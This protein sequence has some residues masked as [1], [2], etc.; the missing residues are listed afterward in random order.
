MEQQDI[1]NKIWSNLDRL[2]TD[3]NF[4][5]FRDTKLLELIGTTLGAEKLDSIFQDKE[6]LT[7]LT[8]SYSITAPK[9]VF[10]FIEELI[11]ADN[12]KSV[13]DPWLT[14]SSPLLYIQ[15]D[16]LNGTCINQSE[17]EAIKTLFKDKSKNFKLGDTLNQLSQSNDKFDLIL[18]FPPF[19]M[20]TQSING[21]K[22][23]FDFATTLLLKCGEKIEN[24]GKMIFL[25][26]NSFLMDDKVKEAL[27]KEG[28]FVEAVFAIPSGA[29]A[30]M[31][32]ISSNLILVSKNSKEK[33]FVAE[34]SQDETTNKT[35][36]QNFKS[37]KEGKAVQL[38]TLIDLSEF[39]SLNALVSEKEMQELVKRIGYPPILLT[40]ISVSI[41]ALKGDNSED[42]E[43]LANSIYLPKVGNSPVVASLSELKIKPKNYYQIQLDETKANSIYVA[44]YFNTPVGKKLRESLEAGVVI[45]QI[46][47]SQLSKCIFFL[48]DLTTQADLIEV[49]NKIQQFSF[50]LAELKRNLWKQPKSYKSI[51]KELKTINQEEKLENW[52]DK[53]PFPISSIL[54]RYYATKDNS[55]KIEHLFHFFEA[56]SEFLSM[57]ML[58]ALVQ[59]KEFYKEESHKWIGKDEKFQNWY[60]RATFGNWNNLTSNLSKAIRTYLTE[61]D[62]KEYCKNLFGNPSE[63]FLSMITSKGIVNV[64]FEVANLRNKWKGHGGITNEEE[65]NQRVLTLEQQLNEFR[66]Y[67][68]DAFEDTRMLSP[69][70]SSFED[71]IFT[72]N[73]KE[74]IGARTPFNEITIKSL[75]PLDRKKLYLSNSQQ[76][77]PLELLPFIKFIEASDAIYFYTSIESKD[78]RWVSYHFDKEAELKQPAD[79]ELF[80][81]FD[82]LK[83]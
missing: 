20:W 23:P 48:P 10:K 42:V 70:T 9:Y 33:T 36:I 29:F 11:K 27:K 2:R 72:F 5:G 18:S 31:T 13:L 63:A 19:G 71:G 50:R 82:F 75:I 24:T 57:L 30:P 8:N 62:K 60:L 46:S 68:A 74:L 65:N 58:S 73:A 15:A 45:P 47:K 34:V 77:K 32:N 37:Q 17:F 76:T 59:D 78:V 43:H 25:V 6:L 55:K 41:N 67:I 69:T 39:K 51:A 1:K 28:L 3:R 52:I 79:N 56:F 54:W 81:A 35:I 61:N 22:S 21:T 44:N 49:D 12:H 64:L 40:D 83:P 16:N 26:S 66:K 7:L 4:I 53:L 38:G 14:L 80:K